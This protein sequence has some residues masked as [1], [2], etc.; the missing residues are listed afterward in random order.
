VNLTV[1]VLVGLAILWI[2]VL[3]P[4]FVSFVRRAS[5]TRSPSRSS[6]VP[7]AMARPRASQST[8][9]M[10]TAMRTTTLPYQSGMHARISRQE[11]QRRRATVLFVLATLVATSLVMAVAV[12]GAFIGV[13]VIFDAMLGAY[14]YFLVQRASVARERAAKVRELHP[15]QP[16]AYS[17]AGAN[18]YSEDYAVAGYAPARRTVGY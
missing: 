18:G 17:Y 10:P 8:R 11:A 6:I 7:S 14:M 2:M 15:R 3:A 9:P 16:E 4:E 13:N 1:L 12:G 5:S